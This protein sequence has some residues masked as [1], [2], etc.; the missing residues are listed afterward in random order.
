M[1][2]TVIVF[3]PTG[4]IASVASMTAQ[5][6]GAK[7]YL[8]MR[9]PQK[10]IPGLSTET[11]RTGGYERIQAD[12]T[13]PSIVAAAVH[14]S[15][16]KRAFIYLAH[17]AKD[18]MRATLEALKAAGIEY[19]VFL[20]S[21]TVTDP[22][23]EVSAEDPIAYSHAQVEVNLEEVFGRGKYCAIRPGSFITNSLAWKEG[24]KDG[25]VKLFGVNFQMDCITPGDM[26]RVSG[27]ILA[28]GAE[29]HAVYLYGPQLA[30][31]RRVA[32]TIAEALGVELAVE[33]QTAEEAKQEMSAAGMPPRI[34]QWILDRRTDDKVGAV[35]RPQY[36][37]GVEN[38]MKYTGR[39][40]TTLEEWATGNRLLFV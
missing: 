4:N 39:P 36:E 6:H 29:E 13:K 2:N 16:A 24:I 34:V 7:V 14:Q 33:G 10:T 30:S 26:G 22:A 12:L 37:E 40:A 35:V 20:G 17:G 8:A 5:E 38:V 15:G 18:H 1:T 23:K 19:V 21:F 11:E 32:S 3:G 9:D 25:Y 31:Q 28:K 27:A